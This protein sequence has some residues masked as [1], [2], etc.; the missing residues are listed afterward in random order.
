MMSNYY[1]AIPSPNTPASM[2]G[3][4][5]LGL[6]QSDAYKFEPPAQISDNSRPIDALRPQSPLHAFV[7]EY[8]LKRL[9]WSEEKMS[10]FYPRWQANE[11]RLQAYVT[12][13]KY[14]EMMSEMRR[15]GKP[16]SPN[17]IV[18]PYAWASQQTIVTYLLHTFGGR[19]PII[20]VGAYRGEQVKRAK[21]MEMLLQYNSDYQRYIYHLYNFFT[22]GE[23]YGLSVQRNMWTRVERMKSVTKPASPQMAMFMGAQGLPANPVRTNEKTVCFEGNSISV[24]NPFMFFPDPR[25]PMVEVADKGEFVFWRAFEG[26][27]I[28]LREEA[29][30]RLKWVKYAGDAT[31]NNWSIGAGADSVGSIRSMGDTLTS[32]QIQQT[33]GYGITNNFQV[34]QGTVEIIPAE[35]GLSP[36]RVPEKWLFTILNKSQI[37]QAEPVSLNHGQHPISVAEPNAFG[38]SFGQLATADLLAPTQ[39]LMSWLIN[40]HMFNVRASLNN[41]LVVDPT[42]VEMDDLLDP[43]PGGILRLKSTPWGQIDPRMAVSQLAVGDVTRSHLQDYQL[44]QRMGDSLTGTTDNVRGQQESGGRKTATE[45]RTSFEA[46]GSRLASRAML[47]SAMGISPGASQWASNY[48]QFL[49]ME[50]EMRVLG[51]EGQTDSVRINPEEI[52]GDFFFP[53]HDGTLPLDKVAMLQVWKEIWQAVIADPSGQMQQEY[54]AK[55]IFRYMAQLGGAQNIDDFRTTMADPGAIQQQAQA[56]NLVPLNGLPQAIASQHQFAPL[57]LGGP[58]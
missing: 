11:M 29:N 45:V 39:D 17:E 40:S 56:G 36:S 43:Q 33:Y 57:Q 47:Y 21:N 20:Q 3:S 34:D 50:F 4:P 58:Q 41:F 22:N 7:L 13:P 24:I 23:L 12:L 37:V 42:K 16:G 38:H 5:A 31:R 25:V 2:P 27:H 35:L 19:K 48:Q 6:G 52:E 30:G 49:T 32:G 53:I 8:L 14:D 10:Q 1:P 9:R 18:V 28:L 44:A 46:G 55:A 51:R 54:N 15:T 26:R